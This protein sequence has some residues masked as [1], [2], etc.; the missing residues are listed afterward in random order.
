[1]ETGEHELGCFKIQN[2][3]AL[4]ISQIINVLQS[5]LVAIGMRIN[6]HKI[7]P[8]QRKRSAKYMILFSI[9]PTF[10]HSIFQYRI[11]LCGTPEQTISHSQLFS[12]LET[13]GKQ[14]SNVNV[15]ERLDIFGCVCL[16]R[17]QCSSPPLWSCLGYC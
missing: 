7:A 10:I 2:V 9:L 12:A 11:Q 14:I 13:I 8:F 6:L 3:C 17:Q 1:M 5:S 16:Q 15:R 4:Y